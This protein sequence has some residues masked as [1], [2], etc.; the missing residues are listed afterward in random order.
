MQTLLNTLYIQAERAYLRLD[1]ETVVVEVEGQT[2]AQIP[3]H[4]LGSLVFFGE[5]MVSPSLLARCAA[6]GRSITWL[7]PGGHFRARLEGPVTGNV[8]LRRR[9][10]EVSAD[11]A[12]SLEVARQLVA[13]K[14][15]NM[16]TSILRSAR[17]SNAS[18]VR[19]TLEKAAGALAD[20]LPRLPLIPDLDALRGI[21]GDATRTYFNVFQLMLRLS[22]NDFT[23]A[24]RTR[25]PPRDPVNALISFLYAL[26]LHDCV[27][28]VQGVG[29]DPQVGFLHT[30]RSGRP[31]LGLDLME[32]FRPVLADRLA[33]TLLNRR[34]LQSSDFAY[35]PGGAVLLNETGRKTVLAA[36]QERKKAEI[37]HPLLRQK[38]ALGLVPHIQA[39]LLARWLRGD[40]ENYLPYLHQ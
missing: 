9:Q 20:I 36:Y 16:R 32:E 38:I 7:S 3:L 21:E 10:H 1:H 35:R 4:H 19:Q 23:F 11:P 40:L 27:G 34:Q 30:L 15:R 25:R 14:I 33:L 39:R 24:G 6:D 31:A 12:A 8:L 37:T 17:E 29:L 5:V 26:L 28:A 2:K 18:E 22:G 13:G